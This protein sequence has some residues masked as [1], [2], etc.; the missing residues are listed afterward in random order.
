MIS[1]VGQIYLSR[2]PR[3]AFNGRDQECTVFILNAVSDRIDYGAA[4]YYDVLLTLP[5]GNTKL[6]AS[7]RLLPNAVWIPDVC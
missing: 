2:T 5:N 3:N 1:R 7:Y 6:V 4:E